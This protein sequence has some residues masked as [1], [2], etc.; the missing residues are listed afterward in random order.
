[1][2]SDDI[3]IIIRAKRE[4]LPNKQISETIQTTRDISWREVAEKAY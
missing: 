3:D 4:D 2:L 1:M